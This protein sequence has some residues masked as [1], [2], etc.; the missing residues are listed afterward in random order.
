LYSYGHQLDGHAPMH[1]KGF[2]PVMLGSQQIANFVQSSL[3]C[4]GTLL[5]GLFPVCIMTAMWCSRK[6]PL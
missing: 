1:I 4:S 5:L 6:E 3:P 2:T